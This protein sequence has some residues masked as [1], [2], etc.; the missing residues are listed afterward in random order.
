MLVTK[1]T[2]IS[3]IPLEER[4]GSTA[5]HSAHGDHLC[6]SHLKFKVLSTASY[7]LSLQMEFC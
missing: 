3:F 1:E 7:V 5:V 4:S 6:D 2:K